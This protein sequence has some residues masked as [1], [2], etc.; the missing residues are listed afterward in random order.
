MRR[1]GQGSRESGTSALLFLLLGKPN[2]EDYVLLR[3][4][5]SPKLGWL[6]MNRSLVK[7]SLS[8]IGEVLCL[9]MELRVEVESRAPFCP[10]SRT[11]HLRLS[12]ITFGARERGLNV[13]Q[14]PWVFRAEQKTFENLYTLGQ[15]LG[16]VI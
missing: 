2:L 12:T 10:Y 8:V 11:D 13:D 3:M 4:K 14:R 9:G 16:W 15:S 5:D 1:K 6:V 7:G